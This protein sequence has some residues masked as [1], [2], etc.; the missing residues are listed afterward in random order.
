[1]RYIAMCYFILIARR[2][3]EIRFNPEIGTFSCIPWDNNYALIDG[4]EGSLGERG[5]DTIHNTRVFDRTE[6]L[7]IPRQYPLIFRRWIQT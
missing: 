4:M 3:N 2:E 5:P 7:R 6:P 1:M